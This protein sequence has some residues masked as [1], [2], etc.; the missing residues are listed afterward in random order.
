MGD[1]N[2]SGQ[3]GKRELGLVDSVTAIRLLVRVG[4]ET[5]S[6]TYRLHDFDLAKT[7]GPTYLPAAVS[8]DWIADSGLDS[9]CTAEDCCTT[10]A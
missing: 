7:L 9:Q 10:E 1:T 3:A 8:I 4:P 6:S 5:K 2:W